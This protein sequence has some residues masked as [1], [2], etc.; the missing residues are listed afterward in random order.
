[1]KMNISIMVMKSQ[2]EKLE[3]GLSRQ[4]ELIL[5]MRKKK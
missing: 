5:I 1:M 3:V 2:L 4:L